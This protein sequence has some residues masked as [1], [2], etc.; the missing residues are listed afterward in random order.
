MPKQPRKGKWFGTREEKLKLE[1]CKR[2][3]HE[4]DK[5]RNKREREMDKRIKKYKEIFDEL[6]KIKDRIKKD[7]NKKH[8]K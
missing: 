5:Y 3:Q 8:H 6:E 2:R 7:E 1:E 4:W